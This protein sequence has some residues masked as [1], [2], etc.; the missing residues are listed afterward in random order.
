VKSSLNQP[1]RS[2]KELDQAIQKLD[3]LLGCGR[4][5]TAAERRAIDT[6]SERIREYEDTAQVIPDVAPCELLAYLLKLHRMTDA[7]LAAATGVSVRAIANAVAGVKNLS[8]SQSRRLARHFK[9]RED[10]FV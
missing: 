9:L 3:S 5:V 7:Q 4:K 1:I 10:A 6:L 2:D 8:A